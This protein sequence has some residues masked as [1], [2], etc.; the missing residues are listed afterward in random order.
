MAPRYPVLSRNAKFSPDGLYRYLLWLQFSQGPKLIAWLLHNPSIAGVDNDDPTSHRVWD[1]S[2]RWGADAACI[3]NP[4][5]G[6]ATDKRDLWK[7]ADPVGPDNLAVIEKICGIARDGGGFVVLGYGVLPEKHCAHVDAVRNLVK[8]TG[9]DVRYLKRTH[10]GFPSH[11]LYIEAEAEPLT[12]REPSY[13]PYEPA[14]PSIPAPPAPRIAPSA[15][16]APR[17]VAMLPPAAA[18]PLPPAPVDD[19]LPKRRPR[20]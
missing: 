8:S 2:W 6:V 14:R 13:A 4:W 18:P 17:P 16:P 19:G 15:A 11:P 7:L 5:A 1:F 10:Q 12:W 3:I 9:V 20:P